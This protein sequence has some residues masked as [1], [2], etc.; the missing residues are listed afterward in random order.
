MKSAR[1]GVIFILFAIALAGSEAQKGQLTGIVTDE[2]GAVIP[3]AHV[4]IHWN[5]RRAGGPPNRDT[6]DLAVNT[7]AKGIYSATLISGF[8][9]V[10]AHAAGFTPVCKTVPIT[11]GESISYNTRLAFSSV[12]ANEFGDKF[13]PDPVP[14]APSILPNVLDPKKPNKDK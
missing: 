1:W 8:Y 4:S 5:C 7:D 3:N 12:I 14:V 10:C 9:D 6:T 2:S 13:V 11:V